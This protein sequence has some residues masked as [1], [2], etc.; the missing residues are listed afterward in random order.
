M[1]ADLTRKK[2]LFSLVNAYAIMKYNAQSLAILPSVRRWT[3]Q[4]KRES[5]WESE[6]LPGRNGMPGILPIAPN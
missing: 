1:V 6:K 3:M 4:N 2:K 5:K